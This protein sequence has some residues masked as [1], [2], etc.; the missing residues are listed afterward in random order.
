MF[1]GGSLSS[2]VLTLSTVLAFKSSIGFSTSESSSFAFFSCSRLQLTTPFLRGRC[3]TDSHGG[4]VPDIQSLP[5][6]H[7]S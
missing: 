7:R 4:K 5:D 3:S 2:G 1:L 6:T